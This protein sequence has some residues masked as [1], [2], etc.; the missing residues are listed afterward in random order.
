[1]DRLYGSMAT[2]NTV[3]VDLKRFT[4][5]S[6]IEENAPET[7]HP[8]MRQR[9]ALERSGIPTNEHYYLPWRDRWLL[10]AI[11]EHVT[12]PNLGANTLL[13]GQSGMGRTPLIKALPM[14]DMRQLWSFKLAELERAVNEFKRRHGADPEDTG[15]DFIRCYTTPVLEPGY[16]GLTVVCE[17]HQFDHESPA[18]MPYHLE[19]CGQYPRHMQNA[20]LGTFL[21]ISVSKNGAETVKTSGEERF[22]QIVPKVRMFVRENAGNIVRLAG[23]LEIDVISLDME[24]IPPDWLRVFDF[25]SIH[26]PMAAKIE[27]QLPPIASSEP[28]PRFAS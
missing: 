19:V 1:M 16:L 10:E 20:Q 15:G 21:S 11:V 2:G 14:M 9:V 3:L 4:V 7:I 13:N 22:E 6:V 12:W 28:K 23:K 24:W 8:K 17:V 18:R 25:D 5:E 26:L 27:A